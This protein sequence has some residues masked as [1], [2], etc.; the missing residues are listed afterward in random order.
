MA[1]QII[2]GI[3]KAILRDFRNP[4][5]LIGFAD[6]QNLSVES[7]SSMEDITGGNKMFPIASFKKDTA[8]KVTGTNATFNPGMMEYLEGAEI[9]TGA[10]T[11]TGFKEVS[12]PEDGVVALPEGK[13]PVADSVVVEG[14]T[15]ADSADAIAADT[16]F[17]SENQ[18]QFATEDAGKIAV[19]VWEYTST[20]KATEYSMTQM[21]LAKPFIFDYIFD[22]YDEDSQIS[23]EG[24]I[25][26]YKAQSASGFKLDASHQSPFAPSFEAN[27]KDPQRVDGKMWSLF[28]DGVEV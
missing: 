25:K 5:K 6:L 19:I 28:I 26:I 12:I 16:Y 18:V 27:A 8:I 2:Y 15:L 10:K 7:T 1:K 22:I 23:H 3:G 14:M 4:K 24:M 11:M 17:V 13:T 21:S 20:E 9:T